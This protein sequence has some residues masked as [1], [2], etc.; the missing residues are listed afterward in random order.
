[1]SITGDTKVTK[2]T[3]HSIK[4]IIMYITIEIA[5]QQK[6]KFFEG[7]RPIDMKH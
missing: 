3:C 1:M 2:D 5:R 6:F 7:K 4:H